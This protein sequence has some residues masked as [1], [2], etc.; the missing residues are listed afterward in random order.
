MLIVLGDIDIITNDEENNNDLF[1][2]HF[3]EYCSGNAVNVNIIGSLLEYNEF[4]ELQLLCV[5]EKKNE[6]QKFEEKAQ[7]K[8]EQKDKKKK[9]KNKE[10]EYSNKGGKHGGKGGKKRK[11]N[12]LNILY[13]IV[14]PT[15]L[16]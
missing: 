13:I 8:E 4:E 1:L 16:I 15:F 14:K 9:N 3:G 5:E 6:V 12:N 7:K 2:K 11:K 10:K